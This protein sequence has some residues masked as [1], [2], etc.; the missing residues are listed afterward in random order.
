MYLDK[1]C[2]SILQTI[3]DENLAFPDI[4]ERFPKVDELELKEILYALEKA[5]YINHH[6]NGDTSV[7]RNGSTFSI[8]LEGKHAI[9]EYLENL[10]SAKIQE[11]SARDS[12]I[13]AKAGVT[14]CILTAISV[15][16]AALGL[17][18]TA[19]GI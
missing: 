17:L 19:L 6:F 8:S 15:L 14:C 13:A 1:T 4:K 10:H 7:I 2:Y 18:K 16:I 9:K 11:K 12:S 3:S 5:D